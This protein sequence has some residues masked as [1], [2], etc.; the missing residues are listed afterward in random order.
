MTAVG[1]SALGGGLQGYP[2]GWGVLERL[3][4]KMWVPNLWVRAWE[5]PFQCPTGESRFQAPTVIL[6]HACGSVA[7]PGRRM[8]QRLAKDV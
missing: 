4:R 2:S 5:G 6:G 1:H 7:G 3:E 8:Y